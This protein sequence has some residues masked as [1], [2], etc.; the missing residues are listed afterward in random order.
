LENLGVYLGV[1]SV[2]PLPPTPS[3]LGR[4]LKN[5]VYAKSLPDTTDVIYFREKKYIIGT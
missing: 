5:Q 2:A 4:G 1:A 3:H